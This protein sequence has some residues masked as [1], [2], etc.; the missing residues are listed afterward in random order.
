[1]I[2][3]KILCY[4]LLLIGLMLLL[5]CPWPPTNRTLLIF[6]VDLTR[7]VDEDAQ[8]EALAAI[9]SV[10]DQKVLQRGDTF[11]VIPITDDS[12]TEAQGH[13]LRFP[14]SAQR[15]AY[16]EDIR[17][18]VKDVQHKLQ[19]MQAVA[20]TRPYKRSDILG[21]VELAAEELNAA[22][23]VSIRKVV[24][25][26]DFIQ[27]DAQYDF[28]RDTNFQNEQSAEKLARKLSQQRALSF[29]NTAVYMGLLRSSDLKKL[30]P[31][32]RSAI[33][34]FWAEYFRSRGAERVIYATD[35]SGSLGGFLNER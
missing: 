2:M 31:E 20:M 14:L 6:I 3:K 35:G 16:D 24:L 5:G 12:Q 10:F 1:M 23:L 25:L 17:R 9:Q 30:S 7:S 15:E 28:K 29:H 19:D 21:S 13:I 22:K 11:V 34:S 8:A 33:R 32:K 18:L 27:D 26:S 4:V